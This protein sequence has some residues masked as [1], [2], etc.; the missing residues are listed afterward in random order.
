MN[1]CI[2]TYRYLNVWV[3]PFSEKKV[4]KLKQNLS[5]LPNHQ[6]TGGRS[7]CARIIRWSHVKVTKHKSD[8]NVMIYCVSKYLKI[9]KQGVKVKAWQLLKDECTSHSPVWSR[10]TSICRQKEFPLSWTLISF[11]LTAW[12]YQA[13]LFFLSRLSE[14]CLIYGPAST[15]LHFI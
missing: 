9:L 11:D 14:N 15:L 1:E 5:N 2:A 12:E 6:E 3:S 7:I 4:W 10:H 8:V 13:A